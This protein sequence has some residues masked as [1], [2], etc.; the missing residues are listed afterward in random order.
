MPLSECIALEARVSPILVIKFI[1]FGVGLRNKGNAIKSLLLRYTL[2]GN[3]N[4]KNKSERERYRWSIISKYIQRAGFYWVSEDDPE[5][6]Y[7]IL[8]RSSI[9]ISAG[10]TVGVEAVYLKKQSIVITNS[11]YNGIIPSVLLAENSDELKNCLLENHRNNIIKPSDSYIYGAWLMAYGTEFQYFVPT[12]EYSVL[13]GLM[14]DGTRIASPGVFQFSI[15]V[16]KYLCGFGYKN[17]ANIR[18]L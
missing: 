3:P 15:E 17:F 8:N 6:T 2:C 14:K 13:Y 1:F 11:F 18:N 4:L 7:D 16:F 12:H 5:S 9:V 10:S